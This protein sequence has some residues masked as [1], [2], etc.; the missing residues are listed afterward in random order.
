VTE[1]E[2]EIDPEI[3]GATVHPLQMTATVE[4]GAIVREARDASEVADDPITATDHVH[5]CE[6]TT[7]SEIVDEEAEGVTIGAAMIGTGETI[8]VAMTE[9]VSHRRARGEQEVGTSS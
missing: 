3:L 4:A 7:K 9:V 2:G 1:I 5:H 6:V 8:E